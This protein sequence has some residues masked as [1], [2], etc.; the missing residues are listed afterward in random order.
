V[1]LKILAGAVVVLAMTL[2]EPSRAQSAV[3][4][5]PRPVWVVPAEPS[6]EL[7]S[8]GALSVRLVD[9]QT[10]VE[11][12]HLQQY[13]R[14][15]VRVLTPEGLPIAGNVAVVWLPSISKA[16]I[17]A[18]TLRRGGRATELLGDG[19]GF[20]ILR[21]EA[22]LENGQID[23]IVTAVMSISDLRVGDE[24]EFSWTLDARNPVLAG[25]VE[26]DYFLPPGMRAARLFMRVSW[27][28]DR[29][30]AYRAGGNVP[31][32]RPF[33]GAGQK[34]YVIDAANFTAPDIPAAAPTRFQDT[35]RVV[36]S[37]FADWAAVASVMEP[38]YRRAAHLDPGS[39]VRE[40]IER[41]ANL[42]TDAKVRASEALRTVQ[43]DVRYFARTD[44]LGGY[45]PQSAEDVW[46][47]RVGDCKGKVALLI[48]L[49]NG[50]GIDA[51]PVLVSAQRSDG[52]DQ[53]LPRPGRFDHVIVRTVIQKKTYWLDATRTGDRSIDSAGLYDFRWVLPIVARASNLLPLT[54]AETQL[55]DEEWRL[56]LD[57]TAGIDKPAQAVATAVLRREQAES[58]RTLLAVLP[59]EKKDEMLRKLWSDRHD[60][61]E[62]KDLATKHDAD[63]GEF[64]LTMTGTGTMDWNTSGNPPLNQYEANKARL[65]QTLSPDR[66]EPLKNVAPVAIG[67]QFE[68]TRQTIFLPD[69]GRGFS[70][71]GGDPIDAVIGGIRYRRTATLKDGQFEMW[72]ETKARPGE[73]S[74]E[75]AQAADLA[76]D[77]LFQKQLF[78]RLPQKLVS[79]PAGQSRAKGKDRNRDAI[80][81]SG[82]ISDEDYPKQAIASGE[83]GTS[84]LSFDIG[85][86]GR[87]SQCRIAQTSS[88]STL[89]DHS[90]MM[91][92]ERFVFDPARDAK[93]NAIPETKVQRITWRLPVQVEPTK[94]FEIIV[95]YEVDT[96]GIATNCTAS[97]KDPKGVD[98]GQSC[99]GIE[100]KQ[101]FDEGVYEAPVR[102]TYRTSLAVEPSKITATT[103]TKAP[104]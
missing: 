103:T 58:V 25:H 54:A 34:G 100:G 78:I 79:S 19:S 28:R 81:V 86:D 45:L 55:A 76:S 29:G 43:R 101:L 61:I 71:S 68:V 38:L 82:S 95:S 30:I 97:G 93:G 32:A 33:E 2:G 39:P 88:S 20:E 69:G 51:E 67:A 13:F 53:S 17:H 44:G 56:D 70:L 40:E 91:L 84:V 16:R 96:N 49:L 14:Q 1:L 22:N 4:I 77:D 74:Y 10:R 21:R 66:P 85:T 31:K 83:A 99:N 62:I 48:A 102:I 90:C 94:P 50:L 37:D 59:K 46:A 23:G 41:I 36:L 6:T 89:D 5:S 26:N 92:R 87:V 11:G 98:V 72:T 73:I 7:A 60:W 18:L 63:S 64:T 35:N 80:L 52:L 104:R 15:I 8:D 47:R 42:S 57:A 9:M 12:D 75:A 65:G 24:I 3:D 27:P